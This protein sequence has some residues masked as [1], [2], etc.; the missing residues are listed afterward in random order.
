MNK[1]LM[2]FFV[3][4]I[5][6]VSV[7]AYTGEEL[8]YTKEA[9]NAFED[10][11]IGIDAGKNSRVS[12]EPRLMLSNIMHNLIKQK[13][14]LNKAKHRI[15]AFN[16]SEVEIIKQSSFLISSSLLMLTFDMENSISLIEKM[17][18]MSEQEFIKNNGTFTRQ[19]QEFSQ[20]TNDNWSTYVE[21]SMTV[22]YTLTEDVD[23]KPLNA[24]ITKLKIK[25]SEVNELKK[26]LHSKFRDEL[27]NKDIS[28]Y[29]YPPI[30]LMKF[31][32]DNWKASDE[33]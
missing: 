30:L 32:N 2:L 12:N 22:T 16:K 13:S 23:N 33:K 19:I 24:K 21:A 1:S 14:A 27:K 9:I 7:Y 28:L 8:Y 3:L 31:L 18:N 17:L 26:L 29:A 11:K 20:T 6:S 5:N 10:I 4:L 25:R 15:D